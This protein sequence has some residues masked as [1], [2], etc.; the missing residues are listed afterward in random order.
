LTDRPNIP[1]KLFFCPIVSPKQF[2]VKSDHYMILK[3]KTVDPPQRGLWG[4]NHKHQENEEQKTK[5]NKEKQ[6]K[7]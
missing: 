3:S 4:L 1:P 6:H 2:F 5:K 7:K